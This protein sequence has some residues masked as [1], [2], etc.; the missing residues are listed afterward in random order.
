MKQ[1]E[2]LLVK[3]SGA[4]YPEFVII[5]VVVP[6]QELQKNFCPDRLKGM[7]RGIF[8]VGQLVGVNKSVSR[9]NPPLMR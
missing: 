7:G 5:E 9:V 4:F 8:G 6:M 1:I 3:R 2:E